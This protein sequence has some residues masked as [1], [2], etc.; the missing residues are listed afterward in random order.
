MEQDRR[1]VDPEQCQARSIPLPTLREMRRRMALSQRQLAELAG[2]SAN[3]VYLLETN[4]RG[5]YPGTVRK[6]ASALGIASV[7]LVREHRQE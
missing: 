2:V 3:T 4:R 5:A 1:K 7:D 6:L